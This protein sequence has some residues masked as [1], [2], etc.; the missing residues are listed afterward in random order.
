MK[1]I[2]CSFALISC[3]LLVSCAT[4]LRIQYDEVPANSLHLGQ[5]MI[6]A[7]R[8]TLMEES[9]PTY[10][11]LI[12]SGIKDSDIKDGSTVLARIYC[13]GGP[14]TAPVLY[15]PSGLEVKTG[16]IVEFISGRPPKKG[17][18]GLL[19]TV[20]RIVQRY[21]DSS[22]RCRWDPPNEGLWQRV[23]YC[24]W[25]QEAG[26]VKQ[27]GIAPAWFKPASQ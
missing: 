18:A 4:M 15:V 11:A 5:V 22:P 20:T 24:D 2:V 1:H 7:D 19:N 27:G 13:C 10:D 14:T 23:L 26:W 8:R 25:M 16:D 12:A 6:V 17:D 3:F 9:K 21:D